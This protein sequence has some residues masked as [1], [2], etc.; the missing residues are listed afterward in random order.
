[1]G[2]T[3]RVGQLAEA[4]WDLVTM[5]VDL[6]IDLAQAPFTDDEYEGFVG[7]LA[8][9]YGNA[10]AKGLTALFGPEGVGG[11]LIGALP[12]PVRAGGRTALEG[13]EWG[14]REGV[15]QPVS[16][17]M[18]MASIAD[19]R[20]GFLGTDWGAWFDKD[21][22][23]VAREIAQTRSPGQAVA[24]AFMT[25]DI[26]DEDEVVRAEGTWQ[27][28]MASGTVDALS[29][30]FLSPEVLAG[31][32]AMRVRH[33]SRLR[34]RREYFSQGEG[35]DRFADDVG[36]LS[37]DVATVADDAARLEVSV[38]DDPAM[39][40]VRPRTEGDFGNPEHRAV[41]EHFQSH[42]ENLRGK[43]TVLSPDDPAI[44][45]TV[46]HV[47]ASGGAI[48]AEGVIR[49]GG[50]DIGLGAGGGVPE[51]AVSF[52]ASREVAEQ[53]AA[54][55]ELRRRVAV[56]ATRGGRDEV[57]DLV[58]AESQR[59][60]IKTLSPT[61][62]EELTSIEGF[63]EG[64]SI[65]YEWEY[66]LHTESAKY[67]LD[68]ALSFFFRGRSSAGG[69]RDPLFMVGAGHLVEGRPEPL[70]S[71]A[72][73]TADDIKIFEVPKANLSASGGAITDFDLGR[74]LEEIRVYGDVPVGS[75]ADDAA[76]VADDADALA[77]RLREKYFPTHGDGDMISHE[78]AAAYLGM[79][80]FAGGNDSLRHAMRFF[81]GDASVIDDIARE[82]PAAAHRYATIRQETTTIKNVPPPGTPGA[83]A[84]AF[85]AAQNIPD[86]MFDDMAGAFDSIDNVVKPTLRL[87][88]GDQVS[89]S[90]WYRS[91]WSMKPVRVLRDMRPQ[92]FVWAGDANS[93]EHVAR[94]LRGSGFSPD[95][96][97]AFRGEW[98]RTDRF[99]RAR[100]LTPR[101]QQKAIERVIREYFP[102]ADAALIKRLKADFSESNRAARAI[103][104]NARKYDADDNVS[105]VAWIDPEDGTPYVMDVPLTPSQL[106]Q[107]VALVDIKSLR[108]MLERAR[109]RDPDALSKVKPLRVIQGA[110]RRTQAQI[111]DQFDNAGQAVGEI[112][113]NWKAAVLLRP[114][115]AMRVVG[116][117][118]LRM[119]AK[120]GTITRLK[121]LWGD[122]WP[123]YVER[124]L[125]RRVLK[126]GVVDEA[127]VK[128]IMA[129]RT[130]MTGGVGMAALG[131]AGALGGAA[132]SAIRNRRAI[133]RLRRN[134]TIRNEAR[135]LGAGGL[136]AFGR[137][138]LDQIGEG[139]L[140]I[141]G[142]QVDRA[143]GDAVEPAIMF[144]KANSANRMGSFLLET[145]ERR[146]LQETTEEL[147]QWG[148]RHV[149]VGQSKKE[150][151][152]FGK[153]WERIV[154]DQYGNNDVGRIAFDGTIDDVGKSDRAARLLDWLEDPAGAGPQFKRNNPARFHDDATT[155]EW[156][157]QVVEAAD[158][159]LTDPGLRAKLAGGER[160]YFRDVQRL[161][162]EQGETL[163]AF[164]GDIHSQDRINLFNDTFLA[165]KQALVNDL[166]DRIGTVTTDNLS[167]NPY[168]RHVYE[169][170]M[171]RRIE[172][173]KTSA[174]D[175]QITEK[176][177]KAIQ[178]SARR[179]ALQETRDLL[180]DLAERSEFSDML[181]VISPFF[182][183]W[184]EVL[185]RWAGLAWENPQWV[186]R[187]SHILRNDF[188]VGSY[189]QT[190]RIGGEEVEQSDGTTKM[191]G[192]E[193]YFQ[194]R[195]PEFA[196][197]FM[198]SGLFSKAIDEQGTIRF[199]ADSLNMVT[200][201]IPG[202]G[203]IVQLAASKIVDY[204]PNLEDAFSFILPYGPTRGDTIADQT[205]EAFLPAYW[206]RAKAW[207]DGHT[208]S[209]N[210]SLESQAMSILQTRLVE[211][212]E[213]T[214]PQIDFDNGDEVA[215]F[216]QEV[217]DD[218]RN[219]MFLR[220][221][222][223][224]FSPASI[225]FHS[226]YQE[227][228]DYSRELKAKNPRTA[229]EE[230]M[231]YLLDEGQEGFF[232]LSARFSKSNEGLPSTIEAEMTRTKYLDMIRRY[233]EVGGLIIGIEGGGEARWSAAVYERQMREE[234]SP[235]SGMT[236]RERLS[237]EDFLD[238]IRVREGWVEYGKVND[239]VYN[240]MRAR[241]LPN[242][243][244]AEARD[245]V[246]VRRAAIADLGEKYP[247]WYDVY[248]NPDLTKW[249]D[250][251]AGLRAIVKDERLSQR[252]DIRL[253]G[254]YLKMR[255]VLTGE[256][257]SR[258]AAGGSG[259]ITSGS[260][261]D[262][263]AVW[264]AWTDEQM[265]NPTFSDL[266]WRWLE[267]DPLSKVTWPK[268]QQEM[269]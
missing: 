259:D 247:R 140:D 65:D 136:P 179:K 15:S 37:D 115:W 116:D 45:D 57:G 88:V 69:P 92:H 20:E 53:L 100:D 206:K 192:G 13:L 249:E 221:I 204:D 237:L 257:A 180:Y 66:Y 155:I 176:S 161:A 22:W 170:D 43:A 219:F 17:V 211:M 70:L 18:T 102:N 124:A 215:E 151:D 208:G 125:A 25:E 2:W 256:L 248:R 251:I 217:K 264:Q 89:H 181:G 38:P 141:L 80:G 244:V 60:N 129:Q 91:H 188:E 173:F 63:P 143:L 3:D 171:R 86:G 216:L 162:K 225:G 55:F 99:A 109:L 224:A 11:T 93:G 201:V 132:W 148:V 114:A 52:T 35:F 212:K 190:V 203:P 135:S 50:G 139:P 174:G 61:R 220:A 90:V 96:I 207:V 184:Q 150:V 253:I 32:G 235:G 236:R 75:F 185:T 242:L 239:I 218:A 254:E 187:A 12:E 40:G 230:F 214:R 177:L 165:K 166:Y 56:A 103:L 186:A 34:Q 24:L 234:T 29:R 42:N 258:S 106:E 145:T 154:N 262:V 84:R 260:N 62:R 54:D 76:R 46:F 246:A 142:Y 107:T 112:M 263:R 243:R 240:E 95:E 64:R 158:R 156:A 160:V 6:T 31:A 19:S 83:N 245:L 233:P 104:Q 23:N 48:D 73:K 228:I 14:Y 16:T 108:T 252:D 152:R 175:Y 81:M 126:D 199:R 113:K 229:D 119:M 250:R 26:L 123:M 169:T 10:A 9:I 189:F 269:K 51:R 71:W 47:T 134:V 209:D 205:W 8:G 268:S 131:P 127:A 146:V 79:R 241:G 7:T 78:L 153:D 110:K 159:M 195:L 122:D 200:Q 144:E 33:V 121:E 265:N 82:S 133:R 223:S 183:A 98:A 77:G 58:K 202:V 118:Q 167:R 210:R 74:F 130:L 163:D 164:V 267:F 191:V 68:E 128:K 97:T 85:N 193:K 41:S 1:M 238:D 232:A 49:V 5:P 198:G 231:N 157:D 120:I 4:G 36:R 261:M 213:G 28:N 255:D 227:Y 137:S 172:A 138:A 222:A 94:F 30:I 266:L 117:E 226:P 194:F 105:R 178:N 39:H 87:N 59:W 67:D 21:D 182:N 168:F 101:Y 44:P 72:S 196:Q 197:D 149:P 111:A 27:F 147:G